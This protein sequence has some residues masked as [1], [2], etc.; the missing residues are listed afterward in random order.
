M[1][2]NDLQK[3]RKGIGEVKVGDPNPAGIA[4]HFNS[5]FCS[6]G[7]VLDS[8]IPHSNKSPLSYMGQSCGKSFYARLTSGDEVE[9][10]I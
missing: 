9:F 7:A 4:E 3:K 1:V 5:H 10:I 2:S 6:V 8:K